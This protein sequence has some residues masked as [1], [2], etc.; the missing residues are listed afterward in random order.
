MLRS[1]NFPKVAAR[2]VAQFAG[3]L[4]DKSRALLVSHTPHG[5]D[6]GIDDAGSAT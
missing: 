6:V 1:G 5:I 4:P 3:L 2:L